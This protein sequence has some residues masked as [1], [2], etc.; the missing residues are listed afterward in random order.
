MLL[1]WV[2]NSS[3]LVPGTINNYCVVLGEAC[4]AIRDIH[5]SLMKARL[6]SLLV[7]D[8]GL[9]ISLVGI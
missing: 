8:H 1:V 6:F 9:I 7:A 3:A 5:I 4:S 2:L